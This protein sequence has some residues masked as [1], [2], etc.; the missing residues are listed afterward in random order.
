MNAFYGVIASGMLRWM[1]VYIVGSLDSTNPVSPLSCAQDL[2]TTLPYIPSGLSASCS[3]LL[4]TFGFRFRVSYCPRGHSS[5][6]LSP[7]GSIQQ[8]PKR[9]TASTR[10]S[11][12]NYLL[13]TG[14]THYT[15][16]TE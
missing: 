3:M 16:L 4:S 9:R 1:I 10:F 14:F 2:Q 6:P 7:M 13:S 8:A 5:Q 12:G 15:C 11:G